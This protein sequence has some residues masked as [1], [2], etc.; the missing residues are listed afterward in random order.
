[1][2]INNLVMYILM[3]VWGANLGFI[4]NGMFQGE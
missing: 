2:E 3:F 1:M 4:V